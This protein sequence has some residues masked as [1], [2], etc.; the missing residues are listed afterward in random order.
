[1]CYHHAQEPLKLLCASAALWTAD[2]QLF[3]GYIFFCVHFKKKKYQIPIPIMKRCP[4]SHYEA[5]T[6]LSFKRKRLFELYSWATGYLIF[7]SFAPSWVLVFYSLILIQPLHSICS[8]FPVT[9]SLF[10]IS[11]W[12]YE[13]LNRLFWSTFLLSSS[14]FVCFLLWG[15]KETGMSW[16][17]C[18][19]TCTYRHTNTYIHKVWILGVTNHI[20]GFKHTEAMTGTFSASVDWERK[21]SAI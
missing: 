11:W 3:P 5:K 4:C 18:T 2:A 1:M 6:H 10:H 13:I 8:L 15:K 17:K 7:L 9:L 12:N 21:Y 14:C 20:F 19:E 16:H